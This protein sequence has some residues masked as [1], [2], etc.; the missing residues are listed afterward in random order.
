MQQRKMAEKTPHEKMST[1]LAEM[2]KLTLPQWAQIIQKSIK[3]AFWYNESLM[4]NDDIVEAVRVFH[5]WYIGLNGASPSETTWIKKLKEVKSIIDVVVEWVRRETFMD[6]NKASTNTQIPT[7]PQKYLLD[8]AS[9]K[10]LDWW[11][12]WIVSFFEKK[13]KW[14]W[15]IDIPMYDFKVYLD[16]INQ[17]LDGS[18]ISTDRM[19]DGKKIPTKVINWQWEIEDFLV[20]IWSSFWIWLWKK[21]LHKNLKLSLW[22]P[23]KS[24]TTIQIKKI[25]SK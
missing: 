25:P 23:G 6:K 5:A 3:D 22:I 10:E 12:E 9:E 16:R 1:Y 7:D 21:L 14:E 24:W 20:N 15:H 19:L 17:D 11:S 8:A 18:N 13:M 4:K 2:N